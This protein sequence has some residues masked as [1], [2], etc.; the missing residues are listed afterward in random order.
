MNKVFYLG[1]ALAALIAISGCGQDARQETESLRALVSALGGERDAL[2]AEVDYLRNE[3]ED[4]K[5]R[6]TA[7]TAEL[8]AKRI[9]IEVLRSGPARKKAG[10]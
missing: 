4:T 10:R 8:D 7:L 2:R 3:L 1:A 6:V 9:E 5:S